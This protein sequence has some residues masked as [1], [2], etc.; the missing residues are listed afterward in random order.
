MRPALAGKWKEIW[1]A[2]RYVIKLSDIIVRN[3]L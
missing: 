2:Y 3:Q 1:L